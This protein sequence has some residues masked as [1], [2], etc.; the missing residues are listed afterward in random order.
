MDY[1]PTISIGKV[2]TF[3]YI[4]GEIVSKEGIYLFTTADIL[5]TD[6][7]TIED[8]VTFRGEEIHGS[9]RAYFIRKIKPKKDLNNHQEEGPKIFKLL[10]END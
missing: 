9:K 6:G 4:T 7:I 3:D 2:R 5:E 8:I 10:K 1:K